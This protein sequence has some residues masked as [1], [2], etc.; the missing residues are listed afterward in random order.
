MILD[1]SFLID[2][3]KRHPEAQARA[4]SLE[5]DGEDLRIP[6]PALY[7]LWRGV[8]LTLR[9]EEEADRVRVLLGRFPTVSFDAAAAE[10]AG[11]IDA[12]LIRQG[13]MLDPE[14]TMIAGIALALGETLLTRNL[15]HF[16]RVPGLRVQDY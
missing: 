10:R 7:E 16:A 13:S 4:R 6:T 5:R 1:T 2:F 8:H 12:L 14:D 15:R 11:D 9:P 3:L